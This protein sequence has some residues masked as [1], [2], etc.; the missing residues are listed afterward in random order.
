MARSPKERVHEASPPF[1]RSGQSLF[2]VP[3]FGVKI[4]I[5]HI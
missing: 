2:W 5:G 3:V 4:Q 1:L